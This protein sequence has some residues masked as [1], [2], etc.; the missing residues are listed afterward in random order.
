MHTPVSEWYVETPAN[1][2]TYWGLDYPPLSAYQSWLYGK[3]RARKISAAFMR[4]C[5]AA[6][7]LRRLVALAVQRRGHNEE[8]GP[9]A[10]AS[11]PDEAP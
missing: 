1:N 2:L 4:S 8:G 11:C 9:T 5:E 3:A 7:S 10:H 6:S